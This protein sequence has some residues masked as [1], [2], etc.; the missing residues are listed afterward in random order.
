MNSEAFFPAGITLTARLVSSR[1][2][3]TEKVPILTFLLRILVWYRKDQ[4][5]L[6]STL[7]EIDV[8]IT[9]VEGFICP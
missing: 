2:I 5:G 9:T 1:V 7:E 3:S 4:A 8:M 6:L